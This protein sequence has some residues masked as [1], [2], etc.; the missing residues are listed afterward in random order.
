[1][2]RFFIIDEPVDGLVFF[3]AVAVKFDL[4][5]LGREGFVLSDGDV[6]GGC[7]DEWVIGFPCA[8]AGVVF[9]VE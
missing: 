3:E 7:G 9:E 2:Y 1:M 6:V 4:I 5:Q 8:I